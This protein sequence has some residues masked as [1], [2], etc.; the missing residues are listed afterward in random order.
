MWRKIMKNSTFD[1]RDRCVI[2][3]YNH[4]KPFAS[5]LPGIAGLMGIP[6][7]VFY[8]NR[9]QGIT[10][11]GIQDKN[12]PI[13]EFQPANKAYQSVF[14][15][16]FRT[17]LKL[18]GPQGST[19]YEPFLSTDRE[20]EIK[21]TLYIAGDS[22]ELEEVNT[23][24]G[25][26]FNVTYTTLPNEDF[27]ALLRKLVVTNISG[28]ELQLELLDG[29]PSIVPYGAGDGVM[30]NMT[31]TLTAWMGVENLE[32]GIPFYKLRSSVADTIDVVEYEEGNFYLA[33]SCINDSCELLK[34]FVDP[35]VIFENNTSLSVPDAFL[36]CSLHELGQLKQ[37]TT[38]K[39]PCGFVGKAAVLK[40]GEKLTIYS[41]VGHTDDIG[42][43]SRDSARY[44]SAEYMECKFAESE[45]V[46]RAIAGRMNTKTS[47]RVFDLYCRQ[48]YLD[49]VIRGG[50]PVMLGEGDTAHA[51]HVYSRKHGDM[52]RDYN[53]FALL[54]EFYSQGNGNYRDV[55][56]NRRCDVWFAPKT[57]DINVKTFMNLIQADGYNPLV[58][59]GYEFKLDP[60]KITEFAAAT[61]NPVAAQKFLEKP[62]TPGTLIR[63][64]KRC[65]L[66]PESTLDV[67]ASTIYGHSEMIQRA[68]FGE[69]YWT[70]HW[71]YNLDL[72]ESYLSIYP[73]KQEELLFKDC[74]CTYYDSPALVA[75]RSEKHV[76]VSGRAQQLDAVVESR[77]KEKVLAAR[78]EYPHMVRTAH[79]KGDIF[80]T[81][82][83]V[84]LVNLAAIKFATL[85]PEGMGVEMEAN[86]PG[87][88]DALNGMPG[89]FGSS[90]AETYELQRLLH[91]IKAT[92]AGGQ[93]GAVSLPVEVYDLLLQLEKQVDEYKAS[94]HPKKDYVYW[95]D[96]A[97]ERE[98]YRS[99]TAMGF[100]GKTADIS[101]DQLLSIISKFESKVGE[102]IDKATLMAGGMAP[103]Y[104]KYE[105]QE[106]EPVLDEKGAQKLNAAGHPVILVKSFKPQ[107]MPLFLE[108]VVRAMKIQESE[109]AAKSIYEKVKAGSLYDTK[110]KMYKVNAS[111]E[112]EPSSIGRARAFNRGWLENESIW[113]HM[114]YKYLLELL[115]NGLYKEFYSDFT[116]ALIPFLN[117]EVYG[118]SPIE[119][120]SF[121]AGS[122]HPDE[123]VH[124][125][126]Y[127]ARLSGATAEFLSL[128]N[129]MM[130]GQ[131][132]FA[133][134]DGELVLEFK[135]I[136]PGWLFDENDC[137]A[138]RFLGE[139]TVI[140]HNKRRLNTYGLNGAA[141]KC[142]ELQLTDGSCISISGGSIGEPYSRLA[143]EGK[144]KQIE[145]L[146]E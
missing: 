97:V 80:K 51:Y 123:S 124:G 70:D 26:Q 90:M 99:N 143:R 113:I 71:T 107:V 53:F 8:A 125:A 24:L 139:C 18:V 106:L 120:S 34:P 30:K 142:M 108:G 47:S 121:I 129:M 75:P 137:V 130:A 83:F 86:K 145:L 126:G 13:M 133:I 136:L 12:N 29:L 33:A 69:G 117:P 73:D 92:A 40:P 110:L 15:Q 7:W 14:S 128:W 57:E 77:E 39:L 105:V 134:R 17:F 56:Q 11:F 50:L 96:T 78:A 85:D 4:A 49:N 74:S 66:K 60:G 32:K 45:A 31:Y 95:N 3:D 5:F 42:S 127:Y 116:H 72:I 84:K 104:F 19:C 38:N 98:L 1:S 21:Q 144:I 16:G 111:L 23:A 61:Q 63:F 119:G 2:P 44:A 112:N 25:T 43:I 55:N 22:F 88:Y 6:M 138:F 27:A 36:H 135:P 68:D 93:L 28:K 9:G 114:E 91:F 54:P 89:L 122:A 58:V 94:V 115:K 76:L 109:Q 10:S 41:M 59:K 118:R 79:G 102:G 132:P 20:T 67:Y 46:I 82:L 141:V 81:S 146:L 101:L 131:K 87:W 62:F 140:Y 103:T 37:V 48:T 64:I 100:D 52:E 65:G 35:A